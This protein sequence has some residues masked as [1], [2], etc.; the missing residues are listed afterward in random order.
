VRLGIPMAGQIRARAWVRADAV[1]G[2]DGSSGLGKKP[3]GAIA[4]VSFVMPEVEG[5]QDGAQLVFDFAVGIGFFG[6]SGFVEV[7]GVFKAVAGV[8]FGFGVATEFQEF[9]DAMADHGLEQGEPTKYLGFSG[10][11]EVTG[12]GVEFV[13]VG[14]HVFP[15]MGD[16]G[17]VSKCDFGFERVLGEAGAQWVFGWRGEGCWTG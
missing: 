13:G 11:E 3:R 15:A 5:F 8:V 2:F 10:G 17:G 12:D 6:G 9:R 16:L 4:A 1:R 14:R 7:E